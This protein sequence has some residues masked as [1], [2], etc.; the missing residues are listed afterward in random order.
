MSNR[1][2]SQQYN[3]Q[4]KRVNKT[5]V[6]RPNE[7]IKRKTNDGNLKLTFKSPSYYEKDLVIT[8]KSLLSTSPLI[9]S[10]STL[11]SSETVVLDLF[12]KEI[13]TLNINEDIT[14]TDIINYKNGVTY[15]IYLK[16]DEIGN[17][18]FIFDDLIDNI[19]L[20]DNYQI[21][22]TPNSITQIKIEVI[23]D[24]FYI[25]SFIDYKKI[26]S[27]DYGTF[28]FTIDTTLGDG[29]ST[30]MLPLKEFNYEYV[31]GGGVINT[32]LFNYDF[33]V[34]W[35]DGQT[36]HITS[37]DD[38]DKNH[39]YSVDGEYQISITGLCES[40]GFIS[41]SWDWEYI[42]NDYDKIILVNLDY[43]GLINVEYMLGECVNLS[44]VNTINND[45]SK[46]IKNGDLLFYSCINLTELNGSDWN[47]SNMDSVNSMF[48]GCN[49]LINL[50]IADWNVS[51]VSDMRGLFHSCSS[52]TTLDISNWST[53]SIINMNV[54]FYGCSSL[55]TLDVSNWDVSNVTNMTGMFNNAPLDTASYDALLI[56]WS[57]LPSLQNNISFRANLAQYSSGAAATA[58]Q[59][60]IDTY[61][62]TIIDA[63][64]LV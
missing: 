23:N 37:W 25:Q 59:Y 31:D 36:D 9:K 15:K 22:P 1:K 50:N 32:N 56:G 60:I 55:T 10:Y 5:L 51:N 3:K 18:N 39:T 2:E 62:W 11:E 6:K 13:I 54:M 34:D 21:D 14:I 20:W 27:S 63:G 44:T 42:S 38:A 16:Q 58:R 28:S 24:V 4:Q 45:W 35:G 49:N 26:E 53:G 7:I 46:D 43:I 52:L 17:H 41:N 57:Q 12:E 30:F 61:G 48:W 64:E 47:I 8:D 40:L 33:I 29:L 19:Q